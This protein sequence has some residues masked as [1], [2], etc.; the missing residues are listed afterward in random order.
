MSETEWS[1]IT[2]REIVYDGLSYED[3]A[4]RFGTNIDKVKGLINQ[5]LQDIVDADSLIQREWTSSREWHIRS[6]TLRGIHVDDTDWGVVVLSEMIQ[7]R[8]A[9]RLSLES[10]KVLKTK[11]ILLLVL[12]LNAWEIHKFIELVQKDHPEWFVESDYPARSGWKTWWLK[13]EFRGDFINVA[14]EY[15][16]I[17]KSKRVNWSNAWKTWTNMWDL[18]WWWDNWLGDFIVLPKTMMENDE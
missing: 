3:W 1:S 15:V 6:E 5:A 7:K 14:P 12:E 8:V 17:I 18:R 10:R 9:Q 2:I 13:A 16:A 11:D 4:K